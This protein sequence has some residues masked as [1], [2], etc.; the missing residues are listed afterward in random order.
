MNK[1]LIEME[2]NGMKAWCDVDDKTLATMNRAN[3]K[4]AIMNV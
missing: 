2:A 1:R 3:S 4:S